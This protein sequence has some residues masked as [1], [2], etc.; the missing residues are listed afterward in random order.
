MM[1]Q[2][3][4]TNLSENLTEQKVIFLWCLYQLFHIVWL[5][6]KAYYQI[7][8]PWAPLK[9][10]IIPILSQTPK[11]FPEKEPLASNDLEI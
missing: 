8:N 5:I 4:K 3:L 1:V 10:D 2:L 9:N 6:W 11:L 7:Q